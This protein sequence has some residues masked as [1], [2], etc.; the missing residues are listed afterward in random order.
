MLVIYESKYRKTVK[1]VSDGTYDSDNFRGGIIEILQ[2]N[3][4]G[5][6]KNLNIPLSFLGCDSLK[7]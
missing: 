5:I 4:D 6:Q 1:M 2:K 3:I 7:F